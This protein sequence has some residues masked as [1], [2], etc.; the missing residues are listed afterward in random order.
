MMP[1]IDG[2][3]IEEEEFEKLDDEIKK[4]FE[5]KS[6]IVQQQIIEV[7]GKI[8]EIERASDKRIEEWQANIA[9]LTVNS[10]INYIKNKY[11]RH[12]KINKFLTASCK[13]YEFCN[14]IFVNFCTYNFA[15]KSSCFI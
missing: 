9:L 8:K 2:K 13:P 11:K 12:K 1:I 3:T 4:Q 15:S 10:H 6:A 14:I 5:E 7:I